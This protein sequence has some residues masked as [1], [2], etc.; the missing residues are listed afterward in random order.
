MVGMDSKKHIMK[1]ALR[2]FL[3]KNYKEVTMKEIVDESGFSKGGF[4]HYF[5]SKE[6]L[7]REVISLFTSSYAHFE[8]IDIQ[9][10][11]LKEFYTYCSKEGSSNKFITDLGIRRNDVYHTN[12]FTLIFDAIKIV[13]GFR[14]DLLQYQKKE[15]D[16]WLLCIKNARK[17]GEIK[18]TLTDGEIAQ[19]FIS[20]GDGMALY[21][22]LGNNISVTQKKIKSL[23][24]SLYESIKA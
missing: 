21:L 3:Q 2:L 17:N 23:W 6:K 9:K 19:L 16:A 11:S 13:P 20:S 1:V 5:E 10:T 12:L 14:N 4:Y 7:F 15:M 24:D 22:F 8:K 18:S